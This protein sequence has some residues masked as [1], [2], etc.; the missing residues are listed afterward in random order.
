MTIFTMKGGK[1]EPVAVIKGGKSQS[2]DE[3]VKGGQVAWP[4]VEPRK[5]HLRVPFSFLLGCA[6]TW[7]SSCSSSS[8][9]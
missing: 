4:S 5:R 9:G 8:T 7:T 2:Y 3:F 1:L 6:P